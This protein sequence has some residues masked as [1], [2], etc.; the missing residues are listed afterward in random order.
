MTPR[1]FALL[2]VS[3]LAAAT[4]SPLAAQTTIEREFSFDPSR[5][6]IERAGST[7]QVAVPGAAREFRPGMPDLPWRSERIEL[8]AGTRVRDVRVIALETRLL[9]EGVRL[10]S[11][12]RPKPGLDL[13][14]ERTAP[15]PEVF[16][17]RGFLPDPAAALG[18]QGFQRGTNLALVQ[19][20]PVRWDPA[21][22]RL[23][24][25]TRIRVQLTLEP[26]SEL[27]VPRGRVVPEWEAQGG[28]LRPA[29]G[30]LRAAPAGGRGG[31]A[32]PF[33]ATQIP[34][35]LGSPVQY[36]IITDDE[37]ESQFQ[38]LAD[39]K[40]QKG[41][42]A[43]VRTMTFI[44][45]QYPGGADDQERIRT[46]IR[47][48]YSR[49]GTEWVLLGGDTEVL[50]AR[51]AF[52]TFY[53]GSR[54]A[55]DVYYQCLDGNWDADGDSLYGEGYASTT[56]P[57]DNVDLLPDLY[58]G[59]APCTTAAQAQ[60]FVD[61]TILYEKTPVTDYLANVLFFAEVLFP[62]DWQPGQDTI[63]D[64]AQI[65]EQ[66]VPY[67]QA[68]PA[69]HLVR[70]YE[71]YADTTWK[72][73]ALPENRQAV[74]DSLDRGYNLAVHIGHGYR[75]VMHVGDATI[76]N[77]DAGGL[78]NGNRLINLYA[79]N[80]TS[81]AIDFPCIGEAFILN[82]NG[83]AV[84]NIGSTNFDF[85]YAGQVYED[86][87]FRLVYEDSVT[88]MGE[89]H[90]LAKIPFIGYSIYDG[91][92]RWTQMT[93][94]ML[95]DPELRLFTGPAGALAVSRNATMAASDSSFA[96]HVT[97][98]GSPLYGARV[99]G[100]APGM[101]YRTVTT[102]GA[103]NAVL[104]FRPDTV[105]SFTLTVTAFDCVPYQATVG[106]VPASP[107]VLS[108]N[109]P[110]IDDDSSGGTVGNGDHIVDAGETVDLSIT[111]R[112]NGGSTASTVNGTLT[113]TDPLI[114]IPVASGTFGTLGVSGSSTSSPAFRVVAAPSIEDQHEVP[115]ELVLTDAGGRSYRSRFQL[116]VRAPELRHFSHSVVDQGGNSDGRPDPGETVL[117]YV[118]LRNAGT[119]TAKTVTGKLRNFDGMATVIDSVASWGDITAGQEKQGDAL[120]FQ[121]SNTAAK[122]QLQVSDAAGVVLTQMLDLL[123]PAPPVGMLGAGRATSIDL[124]WARNA[125]SE[126]LGYNCYRS[127]NPSGPFIKINP[128]PTDRIAA[129]TDAGLAPLSRYYYKLSAVDSSGNESA[130]SVVGS[131]STNPPLHTIFPVPMG[132]ETP[133]PVAIDHVYSGYPEDIVAGAEALYMLHPDGTAPVDA[134]GAGS[135]HG[136]FTRRG[137]YYAAGA[138]IADLNGGDPEIIGLSWGTQPDPGLT[139]D[140]MMVVVFDKNGQ[141]KW[142]RPTLASMWSSAAVGDVDG[143]GV[144]EIVFG[145]N[146]WYV[147]AFHAD[148]T[149]LMD[150]DNN[151][152]TI[153][154]FKTVNTY[155]NYGTPALADL[156][157]DGH[158]DIIFGTFGGTLYAWRANGTNLPGF[159]QTLT[160]SI[161]D[162]PAVGYLDGPG[163]NQ[164]DIV[165]GT[166]G[167]DSLYAFRANG[168]RRPGFP[169]WVKLGGNNRIPSPA[170]ADMNGDGYLDI[171]VASTGG[172]LYVWDRNGAIVNPW[173][174]VRFST[175]TNY[176]SECSPVVADI[177]GDHMPDIVIGDENGTLSAFSQGTLLPGFPITLSAEV[178]G[179]PALCDCDGDG[180]T[181]IVIAGWDRNLYMW[182]YD[183]PFSP[184]KSPPWP[185]YHHDAARSGLYTNPVFVGV[186]DPPAPPPAPLALEFS[187]PSPNPARTSAQASYAVPAASAGAPYEIAIFDVSGRRLATLE[188][189][190][191]Q[192]GHFSAS[193]N[194]RT[195]GGEPVRNGLYFF[196]LTLGSIVQ[197]RKV[198]VLR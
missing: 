58:V 91:V 95:G 130:Y 11:S 121:P 93:L 170:L 79:I 7:V 169:I 36:V 105:G 141:T 16:A 39:W 102:D 159:P 61:K 87:F 150:G 44:R 126:L 97:K 72:P 111:L 45:Q 92:N 176:A 9:A 29:M 82:P 24:A 182:D 41:V 181:E 42:P 132:R 64:G 188:R 112:N 139:G 34:S 12:V 185:Q 76:D 67:V 21:T 55:S 35:L 94:L 138:S 99:V 191:A 49:W 107:P 118:K 26:G 100:Y 48:A 27:P 66:V 125:E 98:G 83:G 104:P 151:P 174:N 124:T 15:D 134:D 52:T 3:L 186:E 73:G 84:T 23:E 78:T 43:V 160:G 137:Y 51:Y 171:V 31:P 161:T 158:K 164:L 1:T 77:T 196:R 193:W 2:G 70:L 68:S 32:Q 192:A 62:Q 175:S 90:A 25:V 146:Q 129:Y 135:S 86:E 10:P 4:A 47:D 122:L 195:A 53:Y 59:R 8:P 37:M 153:G 54:I 18:A 30:A 131:A 120:V 172:G 88:S 145:T 110:T 190:A 166:A 147:Y 71:N 28:G 106:I 168:S 183:F 189:G 136:D 165:V 115:F 96:V 75:N 177:N 142:S 162:S 128:V 81:N 148:G 57:G 56:D 14:L 180:M 187:V 19:M 179:A 65:A 60:L 152:S 5:V 46:F 157:G 40:T 20:S 197:S 127:S 69:R 85:P 155:Y 173:S 133:A 163:D 89:A 119:G 184:G 178:R 109:P 123:P 154:V 198:T 22:G 194:L 103:G 13:P 117:Y 63:L 108:A 50:P 140:S 38:R 80:C 6:K 143:D 149:E 144:P 113:T 156:D 33:R 167:P 17:H 101:D 74:L 116:V 114:S